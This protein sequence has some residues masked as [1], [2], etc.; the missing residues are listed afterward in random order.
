MKRKSIVLAG[1]LSLSL[2][3]PLA[4]AAPASAAP[5]GMMGGHHDVYHD[6]GHR[7][8]MRSERRPPMPHQGHYHWRDGNWQWRNGVWVWLPGLWIR[9]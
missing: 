6:R 9:F 4:A 5:Y 8:P 3:A 1:L 2:A 7:P